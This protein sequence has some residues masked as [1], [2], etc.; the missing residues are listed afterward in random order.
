[1][2]DSALP[3]AA[4]IRS[5]WQGSVAPLGSKCAKFGRA[6]RAQELARGFGTGRPRSSRRLHRHS[7]KEFACRLP[8]SPAPWS[9]SDPVFS[10]G[11]PSGRLG[12][13]NNRRIRRDFK[14]GIRPL[15]RGRRGQRWARTAAGCLKLARSEN[16]DERDGRGSVQMNERVTRT[17]EIHPQISQLPQIRRR[18][19]TEPRCKFRCFQICEICEICGPFPFRLFRHFIPFIWFHP[20]SSAFSERPCTASRAAVQSRAASFSPRFALTR[21]VVE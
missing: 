16:A 4:G 10:P 6:P 14:R 19:R 1:M 15:R 21:A 2:H 20:R 13:A 5:R 17:R 18:G 8:C 9:A 7:N 11:R 3:V 12:F